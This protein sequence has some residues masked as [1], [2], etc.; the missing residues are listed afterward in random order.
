[1]QNK[2]FLLVVL[3]CALLLVDSAHGSQKQS[4][5]A[6]SNHDEITLTQATQAGNLTLPPD[7]YVVQHH[8]S[9]GQDSI[10]FMRVKQS[11][12]LRLS[13]AYTGWYTD[14]DLI[15]AGEVRCRVRPLSAKAQA[16]AATVVTEG[17]KPRITEIMIKGKAAMYEF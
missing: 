17:G 6:G 12:K 7:T 8:A 3:G 2:S 14:T 5:I 15:K 16:T 11:Q 13:R 1:M 9:H 10:R 4:V